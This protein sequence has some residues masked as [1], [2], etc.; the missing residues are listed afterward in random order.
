MGL[1][2]LYRYLRAS[3]PIRDNP[4]QV[5]MADGPGNIVKDSLGNVKAFMAITVAAIVLHFTR[6]Q[7]I[8]WHFPS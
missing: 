7:L 3:Q 2:S 4:G 8:E 1:G 5:I 6:D